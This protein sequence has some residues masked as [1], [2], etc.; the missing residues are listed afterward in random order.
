M[1]APME[2]EPATGERSAPALAI[3]GVFVVGL[4]A[5]ALIGSVIPR[6]SDRIQPSPLPPGATIGKAPSNGPNP[7]APGVLD[8]PGA[9]EQ[10][11][12]NAVPDDPLLALSN[13]LEA[14]NSGFGFTREM[15]EIGHLTFQLDEDQLPG[16]LNLVRNHPQPMLQSILISAVFSRWAEIDPLAAV[17][18]AERESNPA[19]QRQALQGAI[20]E[21]AAHAPQDA[22]TYV[23]DSTEN[24][25]RTELVTSVLSGIA[26]RDPAM[27]INLAEKIDNPVLRGK[28]IS[29]ASFVW[30]TQDPEGALA[31]AVAL[32]DASLRDETIP[33]IITSMAATNPDLALEFTLQQED[34]KIRDHALSGIIAQLAHLDP[35]EAFNFLDRIPPEL[36]P[37]RISSRLGY[38]LPA[39]PH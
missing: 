10:A 18:Q 2:R 29:M 4:I 35:D 27:A 23:N 30:S 16:A 17:Q 7:A 24:R 9:L 38:S 6:G 13:R 26:A 14:A 15:L 22:W 25:Q 32:D 3:L 21:W 11:R 31:W 37:D 28:A 33:N 34:K 20:S 1:I 5:G 12:L 19:I 8:T 39:F 36:L